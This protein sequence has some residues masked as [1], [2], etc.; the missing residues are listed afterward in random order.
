MNEGR[1]LGEIV[2]V[3]T[4]EFTAQ[5]YDLNDAPAYGSLVCT[6]KF[7]AGRIISHPRHFGICYRV[8]TSSIEAG[9]HAV[10]WGRDEEDDARSIAGNLNS[11]RFCRR[12]GIVCWWA[13]VLPTA[14][15]AQ[16]IPASPPHMHSFRL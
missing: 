15:I 10:A 1:R 9:R 14:S 2:A 11:A 4:V 8:Q 16:R 6:G 5:S 3:S 7:L 13:T 12:P